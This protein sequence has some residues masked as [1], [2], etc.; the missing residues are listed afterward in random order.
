MNSPQAPSDARA[1][2]TARLASAS[3]VPVVLAR[4][5]LPGTYACVVLLHERYGLVEHT[6]HFAATLAAD[7]LVVL[8]PNLFYG[9]GDPDTV[10]RG[11][12]KVE[13][14]DPAVLAA[15]RE[16]TALFG[17][18]AGADAT[19]L[20]MVGVCQTGRYPFVYGAA[21]PLRARVTI[22]G[23]AQ[24]REWAVNERFPQGLDALIAASDAPVLGLFGEKDHAI[25]VDHVRRLRDALER[26]DRSYRVTVYAGAPHGWLNETMPGRYRP[27]IAAR[28]LAELREFL[29]EALAPEPVAPAV[30]WR[31]TCEKASDYDFSR[32]ERLG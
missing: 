3:G 27:A 29:A 13:P 9:S 17:G 10:R 24:D 11:E 8:A 30:R 20:A 14:R 19:R 25:S 7:G 26:H 4:P 21:H 15:L 2:A 32:N 22:Y 16:V 28:A 12:A 1:A 6:E 5:A 31:F 18:I 23:A